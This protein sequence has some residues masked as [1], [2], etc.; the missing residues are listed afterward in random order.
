MVHRSITYGHPV[1]LPEDI[2]IHVSRV[3]RETLTER[4]FSRHPGLQRVGPCVRRVNTPDLSRHFGLVSWVLTL[5][6]LCVSFLTF[7]THLAEFASVQCQ[8]SDRTKKFRGLRP[9]YPV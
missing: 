2:E 4:L 8:D 7:F 6:L 5:S 1:N 9:T 3:G